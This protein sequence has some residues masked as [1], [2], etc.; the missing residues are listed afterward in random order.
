MNNY[1]TL[2]AMV[3]GLNNASVQRLKNTRSQV[4]ARFS[5]T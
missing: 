4:L 3:A 1:H 5:L 2:M